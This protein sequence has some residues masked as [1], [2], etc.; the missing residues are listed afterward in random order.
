MCNAIF[1]STMHYGT[2][3]FNIALS[4]L[5]GAMPCAMLVGAGVGVGVANT[6]KPNVLSDAMSNSILRCAGRGGW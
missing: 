6:A 1:H 5:R 4:I 2:V 3:Q